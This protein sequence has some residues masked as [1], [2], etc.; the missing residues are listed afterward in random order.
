M[1]R[2]VVQNNLDAE[3]KAILEFNRLLYG[4]VETI[5]LRS[6]PFVTAWR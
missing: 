2:R 3:T 4:S 6:C 1:E 5:R